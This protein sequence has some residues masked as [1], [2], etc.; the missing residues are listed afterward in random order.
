MADLKA[1][2]LIRPFGE[3]QQ[4]LLAYYTVYPEDMAPTS[5]AQ[6]FIDWLELSAKNPGHD[7]RMAI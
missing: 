6:A 1:G 5:A 2:R 4:S 7:Q 3:A